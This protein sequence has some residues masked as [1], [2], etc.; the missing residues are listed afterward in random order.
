MWK[1]ETYAPQKFVDAVKARPDWTELEARLK[2]VLGD[3]WRL[4][5]YEEAV[6]RPPEGKEDT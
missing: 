5:S 3:N 4:V 1:N 2:A 6:T